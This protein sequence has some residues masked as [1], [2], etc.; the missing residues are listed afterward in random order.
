MSVPKDPA[1]G[2]AGAAPG[3]RGPGTPGGPGAPGGPGEAG[4]GDAPRAFEDYPLTRPEYINAVIHFYRGEL[5]RT[6]IWRTRIDQTTNW[7]I[8]L[9][10]GVFSFT[11]S[12]ESAHHSTLLFGNL[13]ILLFLV[14]EAR[15]YRRFDA[16]YARVRMIEENFYIPI[17]TRDLVSPTGQWRQRVAE[18]LMVPKYK[19][20]PLQAIGIRLSRNYI[21]LLLVMLVG[22]FAK[23]TMPSEIAPGYAHS[24]GEVFERM[25][26]GPVP[27]SLVFLTVIV[28]YVAMIALALR[29]RRRSVD[30]E[31]GSETVPESAH[32]WQHL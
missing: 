24:V 31:F 27:S 29:H 16:W 21:W 13:M 23:L 30:R 32:E 26:I 17:L 4:T 2:T 6:T 7:A 25:H 18:D 15:R 19:M 28:F 5:H 9:L 3:P 8:A 10:A 22:W 20:T 11:F 14:I 1:S 12:N